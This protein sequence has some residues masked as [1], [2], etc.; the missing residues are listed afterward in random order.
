MKITQK[1]TREESRARLRTTALQAQY[2]LGKITA[3]ECNAKTLAG[4]ARDI[5]DGR[6]A[7]Q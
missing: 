4:L 1:Q 7:G 2:R 3:A 5:A 6:R